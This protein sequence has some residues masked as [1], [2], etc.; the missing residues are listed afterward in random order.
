[1][2]FWVN[3]RILS[4]EGQKGLPV[5]N[6]DGGSTWYLVPVPGTWYLV[7]G[8]SGIFAFGLIFLSS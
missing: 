3:A 6:L 2:T 1:M 5:L 4:A 7:P 8:G